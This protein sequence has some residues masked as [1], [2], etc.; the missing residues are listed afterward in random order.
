M[1]PAA[2][3]LAHPAIA[4]EHKDRLRALQ[5]VSDPVLL[6]AEMRAAQEELGRRVDRRWLEPGSDEPIVLD[7][8]RFTTA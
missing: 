5:A 7:L 8:D 2:R 3:V 6:L 1:S 4:D